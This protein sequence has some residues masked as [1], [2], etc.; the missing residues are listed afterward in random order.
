MSKMPN[1]T[2]ELIK[3]MN[4]EQPLVRI[5]DHWYTWEDAD[6]DEVN[7]NL[8]TLEHVTFGATDGNGETLVFEIGNI[9]E[10]ELP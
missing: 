6:M 3:N 8:D 10:L 1:I 5:Q 7:A 9:S 4:V 2:V